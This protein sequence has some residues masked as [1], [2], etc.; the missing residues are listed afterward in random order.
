VRVTGRNRKKVEKGAE[1]GK[2]E[3]RNRWLGRSPVTCQKA[4]SSHRKKHK[5]RKEQ[6]KQ[7]RNLGS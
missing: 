2:G 7:K 6:K 3:E 4:S 5:E 1:R